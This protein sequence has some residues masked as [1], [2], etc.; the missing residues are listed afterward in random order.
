[1]PEIRHTPRASTRLLPLPAGAGIDAHRH[2]EHQI[3]YAGRGVLS[4]TTDAGTWIAPANRALW[5]PAGASHAHRAYG[6]T[7]LYLVGLPVRDNP[8]GLTRPAVLSVGPLLRELIIAYTERPG[9]PTAERRRLRGVLLDRLRRSVEQPLHVPVARDPRLLAVCAILHDDPAD[10]RTLAQL[11]AAVGVSDRTLARLCRA[12]LG[13]TFPQWRT[14]LRLHQA[15]CLLAQD[16]PVTVVAHTCGWASTSAF[17]DV[18]RRAF[19]HTPGAHQR[20]GVSTT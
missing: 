5:I 10:T 4:V 18:F 16:T 6:D 19:G 2:D 1:M 13:M 8:L 7:D 20:L 11:G 14:Q 9:D 17:I 12:E 3:A 15:L